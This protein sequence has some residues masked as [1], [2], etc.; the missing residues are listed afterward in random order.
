MSFAE[1]LMIIGCALVLLGYLGDIAHADVW[2][3]TQQV[4][5]DLNDAAI[6]IVDEWDDLLQI[7][8]NFKLEVNT[9]YIGFTLT[10]QPE[11]L[12]Q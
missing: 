5:V 11:D 4:V 3:D 2:E 7:S 6:L 10:F 9:N 1:W 8:D 12:W